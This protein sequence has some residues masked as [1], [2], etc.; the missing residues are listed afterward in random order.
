[1]ILEVDE[2][3]NV[4]KTRFVL[5]HARIQII[6]IQKIV[7]IK[8][9]FIKKHEALEGWPVLSFILKTQ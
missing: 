2:N 6:L 5:F 8:I 3:E 4:V 7:L 9:I 1:M